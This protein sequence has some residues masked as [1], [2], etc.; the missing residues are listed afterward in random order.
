MSFLFKIF[1]SCA[2]ISSVP[3]QWRIAKEVYIPKINPPTNSK[4]E[5]F[6]PIALLNVKGKLFFSLISKR[7]E[8]HILHKNKFVNVAIQKGSWVLGAYVCCLG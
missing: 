7:I 6:R 1:K 4:I 8:D 2:K 3:I 5:D